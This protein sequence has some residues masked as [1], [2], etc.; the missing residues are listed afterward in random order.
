MITYIL[1]IFFI[2]NVLQLT[3]ND[4]SQLNDL[5]KQMHDKGIQNKKCFIMKIEK[6]KISKQSL[7]SVIKNTSK[8]TFQK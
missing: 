8:D 3:M 4:I 7:L 1:K 5:N 6:F 2:E